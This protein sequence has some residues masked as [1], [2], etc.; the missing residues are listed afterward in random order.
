MSKIISVVPNISEGRDQQFISGLVQKL[1]MV[2][3]LLVLDVS[4]D[5]VR[6]RTVFPLPV[7]KR[8]S[9]PAVS[10]CTAKP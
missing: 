3:D 7:P 6:N 9:L 8:R 10:P 2:K 1:K 4:C 5:N